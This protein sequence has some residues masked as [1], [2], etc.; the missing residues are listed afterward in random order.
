MGR[1][2]D[3]K[4][5]PHGPRYREWS[6][7]VDRYTTPPLTRDEMLAYLRT[8]DLIGPGTIVKTL[9]GFSTVVES[10]RHSFP[11]GALGIVENEVE[12][13]GEPLHVRWSDAVLMAYELGDARGFPE[14]TDRSIQSVGNLVPT[15][16]E[17]RLA[18]AD[19]R[20][21]SARDRS[22]RE[23]PDDE[24]EIERCDCGSFHHEY[25]PRE[26]GAPC[27]ACGELAEDQ[28]HRPPCEPGGCQS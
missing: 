11:A 6:S 24:W 27:V 5:T 14:P 26:P 1:W 23:S 12:Y 19:Q 2:I 13:I 9:T 15:S 25:Q 10:A 4:N 3:R 18:R 7:I 8:G 17:E 28:S 20:G 22:P 21:T 16:G